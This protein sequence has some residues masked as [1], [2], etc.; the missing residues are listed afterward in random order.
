M[1]KNIDNPLK[2]KIYDELNARMD[3]ANLE[4]YKNR[5]NLMARNK[6]QLVDSNRKIPFC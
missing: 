6:E 1:N 2:R 3:E 4:N 5:L